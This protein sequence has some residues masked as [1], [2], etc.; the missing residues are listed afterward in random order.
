MR[1]AV[2][3]R[4]RL[5]V[6]RDLQSAVNSTESAATAGGRDALPARPVALF[7]QKAD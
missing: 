3:F 1:Q 6:W 2:V 7:S 5:T 4:T